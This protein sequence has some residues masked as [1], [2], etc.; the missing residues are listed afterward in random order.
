MTLLA[1]GTAHGE[2]RNP[3]DALRLEDLTATRERP[4]FRPTAARRLPFPS[5]R[6]PNPRPWRTNGLQQP[7]PFELVGAVVGRGAAIALLRNKTTDES[8]AC[9]SATR[10][11]AG[12]WR[13]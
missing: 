5:R 13:P 1:C 2:P 10:L 12:E 4:L 8:C 11:T 7:P 6:R 9:A 3:L